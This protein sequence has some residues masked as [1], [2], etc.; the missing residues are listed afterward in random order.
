MT[1]DGRRTMDNTDSKISDQGLGLSRFTFHVSRFKNRPSS[2]VLLACLL[3]ALTG[4]DSGSGSGER[5]KLEIRP[6]GTPTATPPAQP[7]VP[8]TTYAVRSGDA[9][10]AIAATV[11]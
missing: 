4:C 8:P 2:V 1:D 6:A 9:L 7:T 11:G 5:V 10:S 3:L